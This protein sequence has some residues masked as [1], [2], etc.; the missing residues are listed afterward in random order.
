MANP[1]KQIHAH[2]HIAKK[3]SIEFPITKHSENKKEEGEEEFAQYS[4]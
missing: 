2:I 3:I 1:I 4:Q